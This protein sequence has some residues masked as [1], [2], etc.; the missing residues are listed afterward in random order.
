M[1]LSSKTMKRKN[2]L[3]L[4]LEETERH[5]EGGR[6]DRQTDRQTDRDCT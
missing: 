2:D 1:S 3:C 6:R 4:N 5:T